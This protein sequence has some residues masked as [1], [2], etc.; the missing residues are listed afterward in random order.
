M[1]KLEKILRYVLIG[2]LIIWIGYT[3]WLCFYLANF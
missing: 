2:A 1:E 3:I